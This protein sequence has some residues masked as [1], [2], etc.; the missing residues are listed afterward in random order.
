MLAKIDRIMISTIGIVICSYM[1][2]CQDT[3]HAKPQQGH[4]PLKGKDTVNT[5]AVN[6]LTNWHPLAYDS[7]KKYIYLT[8]DDGPQPGTVACYQC[9]KQLGVKASFFMVGLH[10]ERKT[11]GKQIVAMIRDS[12]PQFLLTNHSYSHAWDKYRFFYHHAE[13]ARAD[14]ERAQILMHVP[15]RIIRLPGN[16][17]WVR[18]GELKAS[19]LVKPVTQLLDSAGYNVMGWDLEWNFNHKNARPIQHPEKLAAQV[20][21]AFAK[22]RTHVKNHLVILTHDRMFQRGYDTDSLVKFISILKQNPAYVFETVDHYPG[23]KKPVL[24]L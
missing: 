7:T 11:D 12:Y 24:G 8:F 14:F 20:D 23:L 18:E 19:S 6:P 3:T 21:S 4:I 17:A 10:T 15:Y 2:G 9:C 1:I 22:N 16:S 13:D 5:A